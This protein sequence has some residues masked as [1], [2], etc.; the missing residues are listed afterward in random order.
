MSAVVG[1]R[2]RA[3]GRVA[4][5][6]AG[7]DGGGERAALAG[8]SQWSPDVQRS[9]GGVAAGLAVVLVFGLAGLVVGLG[10]GV[11]CLVWWWRRRGRVAAALRQ[12]Q[13]PEGLERIAGALRSG[14]STPQAIA[15]AGRAVADPLG[16]ELAGLARSMRHGRPL[17]DAVDDWAAGHGDKGTRLVATALVLA[18]KVG[19]A[20]ARALDGVAATLRE[21][22]ELA[23]E[24][25]A[26]ATQ[27]RVSAVVLSLAPVAFALLLAVSDPAVAGFLFSTASGWACLVVGG[28][29]DALGAAWMARLTRSADR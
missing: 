1:R 7:A 16:G 3:R 29:L 19:A 11:L 22:L 10:A 24:R 4:A 2:L 9:V 28:G 21:R 27:A 25:H 13:L 20:P 26:L 8:W 18:T 14:S 15:E 17:V 23:D 12:R 6:A 5:L